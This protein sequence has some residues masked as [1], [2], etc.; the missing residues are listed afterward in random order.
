[1]QWSGLGQSER[2]RLGLRGKCSADADK[3]VAVASAA[4][5]LDRAAC[6]AMSG[7]ERGWDESWAPAWK[8]KGP[9]GKGKAKGK[10]PAAETEEAAEHTGRILSRYQLPHKL[11]RT[12]ADPEGS[13]FVKDRNKAND[14]AFLSRK[15]LKQM[16]GPQ[17]TH[18]LRR[19]GVGLSEAAG[20]LQAGAGVLRSLDGLNLAKLADAL[21]SP[22]VATAL[23]ALNT[24]DASVERDAPGLVAAVERLEKA[25]VKKPEVEEAA[26]KLTILG[27][28]L[29]LCGVHLLPLMAA[30]GD[31]EWW[32]GQ[33]PEGLSVNKRF[34]AWKA[35]PGDRKKMRAA[36]AALL[37]E[38]VEEASGAGAND[39]A[40]LFG[41]V[42]AADLEG[43]SSERGEKKGK[44]RGRSSSDSA[45]KDRKRSKKEKKDKK[46]KKAAKKAK[47][48]K[49]KGGGASSTSALS[50]SLHIP[51]PSPPRPEIADAG[52]GQNP[53]ELKIAGAVGGK[54]EAEVET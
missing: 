38:K 10:W 36:A 15:N 31:P 26:I 2:G 43:S 54:K 18:L 34:R 5:T 33:V 32:G 27:S 29:Y 46:A 51:S 47:K 4:R 17:N 16:L 9:K 44:K 37:L 53:P 48:A 41:R 12:A 35:D 23:Q 22:E 19:P 45:E 39:A 52:E 8:G 11:L 42:A 25:F 28:R 13:A 40:A 21:A 6:F 14:F 1:M 20:T 30:L 3:F 7:W 49:K 24:L 50:S